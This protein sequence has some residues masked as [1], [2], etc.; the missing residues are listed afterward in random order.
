MCR[1]ERSNSTKTR[2]QKSLQGKNKRKE[3]A[4]FFDFTANCGG[5]QTNIKRNQEETKKRILPLL[6]H[7]RGKY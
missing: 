2:E 5:Y 6:S 7:L 3:T 1:P 4:C